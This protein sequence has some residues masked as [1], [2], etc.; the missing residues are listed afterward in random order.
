MKLELVLKEKYKERDN[1]L[2]MWS[3]DL[4]A[5]TENKKFDQYSWRGKRKI[6][7]L[8]KKYAPMINEIEDEISEME[9]QIQES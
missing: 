9:K 3:E 4:A 7:K 1:I 8:S 2:H 6:S 5:L